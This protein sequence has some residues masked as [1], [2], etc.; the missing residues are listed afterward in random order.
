MFFW[1]RV[2]RWW[3]DRGRNIYVYYDG[4]RRRR[5][6]PIAISDRLTR[7]CPE[8]ADLVQTLAR[9]LD[10]AP[11]GPVRADL[12]KQKNTAASKLAETAKSVFGLDPLDDEKGVTDSE[13]LNVLVEYFLFMED[14]AEL[15]RPFPISPLPA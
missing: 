11:V 2:R 5:A 13:A 3:S 6:D 1:S 4:T 8:Y 10:E 7:E 14:I 12:L 9:K 15:A